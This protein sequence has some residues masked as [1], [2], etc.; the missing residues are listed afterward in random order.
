MD[1]TLVDT[2]PY[3]QSSQ[4]ALVESYGGTWSYEQTLG[5]VGQGLW[6]SARM[7]ADAGVDMPLDDIVVKMT[8]DVIR[9]TLEH[10]PW[11]PGAREL[12]AELKEQNV[13]TALVTMSIAPLARTVAGC[14]GFDGFDT[15]VSGDD[16]ENPKPF[17]DAYRL[18][19]ERLGVDPRR[20]V[21]IEDSVPGVES[22]VAAGC[23]TVGVPH[24][25]P[26]PEGP[27]RVLWPTLVDRTVDDLADVL[28][29][30]ADA[31]DASGGAGGGA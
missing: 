22:A 9:Q 5:L 23:A 16:V 8:D 29:A 11:R 3:W 28:A 21:A 15:V 14:L 20:C 2:E 19:A 27:G 10:V 25:V 6:V 7:L 18:A 12:L 26:I 13:P 4:I 31:H 17:P 1:G 24:I 30:S